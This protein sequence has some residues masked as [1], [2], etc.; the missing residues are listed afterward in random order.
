MYC[1]QA[2]ICA[3]FSPEILQAVAVKGLNHAN[4][5]FHSQLPTSAH[6]YAIPVQSHNLSSPTQKKK[7][8]K[9]KK[10]EEEKLPFPLEPVSTRSN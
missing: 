1:L 8:E 4:L 9:R 3:L 10:E 6:V 2:C 5:P 7:E